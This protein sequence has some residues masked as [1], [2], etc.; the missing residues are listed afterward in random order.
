M[1]TLGLSLGGALMLFSFF[2]SRLLLS[3]VGSV[4]EVLEHLKRSIHGAETIEDLHERLGTGVPRRLLLKETRELDDVVKSLVES[5]KR[6]SERIVKLES[7]AELG[8]FA[9][10]LAHDIRSPLASLRLDTGD[11]QVLPERTKQR[12]HS[13]IARIELI[14]KGLLEKRRAIETGT[15]LNPSLMSESLAPLVDVMVEEA[16]IRHDH[17]NVVIDTEICQSAMRA[18]SVIDPQAFQ[19]VLSNLINNAV[20]ALPTEGGES[21]SDLKRIGGTIG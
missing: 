17:A 2:L 14:A 15:P 1:I 20:E 7:K 18:R 12:I 3:R 10:Q 19:R 6:T 11:L 13:S 16:K 21:R 8:R 5:L 9:S 4:T